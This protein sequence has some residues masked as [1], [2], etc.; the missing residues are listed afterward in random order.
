MAK[1]LKVTTIH[2]ILPTEIFNMILKKLNYKSICIARVICKQW[3]KVIDNFKIVDACMAKTYVI[4]AS[5]NR[6]G[7]VE[8]KSVEVIGEDYLGSITEIWKNSAEWEKFCHFLDTSEPEGYDSSG[9]PMKLSR[10]G[11]FLKDYVNLYYKEKQISE[12]H[13]DIS[14]LTQAI[15][16]IKNDQEGYFDVERCLR[17]I[18]SGIRSEILQ[19]IKLL[20]NGQ[21]EAGSWIY[22][23]VYSKVLDKLNYLLG[24][25]H[26]LKNTK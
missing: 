20:K 5:G 14:T 10:Y 23:P 22:Q 6:P 4:I 11:A 25:Y 8:P 13:G 26:A 9:I 15:L 17:C 2:D 16:K 18:D 3:K 21:I 19:N 12:T 24:S 7:A 1:T